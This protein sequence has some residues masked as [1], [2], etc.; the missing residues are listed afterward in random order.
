MPDASAGPTTMLGF[1]PYDPAFLADPYGH[2]RRLRGPEGATHS[3]AGLLVVTSHRLCSAVLRDRRFGRGGDTVVNRSRRSFLAMDPPDHT[4]LRALVSKAFTPRLIERLRPRVR[5]LVDELLDEAVARGDVDLVAALAYP[6]PVTV[7]SELIGIPAG[8]WGRF[9][10]WVD[11]LASG[12]D[13]DF[14]LPPEK[15]RQREQA[16]LEFCEY[17]LDLFARRRAAPGNDLISA[18]LAVEDSG[19]V[20]SEDELLST[21]IL[22]IIAGHETTVSLIGN[23]VLALLRNPGELERFR[24]RVVNADSALD[25]LLRYDAP[26]QSTVRIALEPAD[27]NGIPVKDGELVM[28]MLGA[29]NRDPEMFPDPDRLDLARDSQR[30]LSFGLGIHFCLGAPL[31]RLEAETALTRLMERSPGLAL[32]GARADSDLRYKARFVLR[33]LEALPVRL[34]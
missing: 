10:G 16:R 12:L 9:R 14:L 2:Y 26:V 20:L 30:H 17:L 31:A 7:I 34:S 23:G 11:A 1:D 25:E 18:L 22:L 27:V 5:Q 29:A 6:L 21:C 24:T 19:D 28:L 8:D 4:R 15:I 13:P 32:A 33:G 3:D